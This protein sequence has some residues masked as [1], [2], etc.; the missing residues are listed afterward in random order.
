MEKPGKL[1]KTGTRSTTPSVV[2]AGKSPA[3]YY[4]PP[5][6]WPGAFKGDRTPAYICIQLN[7]RAVAALQVIAFYHMR[8]T[9]Y[10]SLTTA[11]VVSLDTVLVRGLKGSAAYTIT[12][13]GVSEQFDLLSGNPSPR[14]LSAC[15]YLTLYRAC[16]KGL[17]GD[18]YIGHVNESRT[19][20]SRHQFVLSLE[21]RVTGRDLGDCLHHRSSKSIKY[22]GAKKV[23]SHG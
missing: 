12:L 2:L 9:E 13:P 16:V 7:P 20:T 22:Y 1:F 5:D 14:S 11:D 3:N 8:A 19:H 17:V 15:S 6:S 10:L 21:G 23:G 4:R 18:L